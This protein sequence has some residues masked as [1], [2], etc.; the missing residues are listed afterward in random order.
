MEYIIREAGLKD[1]SSLKPLHKEV[2]DI[3]AEA[4]PDK[5]KRTEETLDKTYYDELIS[6]S[7]SKVYIVE[8]QGEIAGFTILKKTWPPKWDIKVQAPVVFMHDLGVKDSYRRRGIARLLF[9]KA[10]EFT[11]ECGAVSLELGVWEFNQSAIDFYEKMGMTTQARK[12]EI[13]ID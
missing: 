1:Y 9:E 6:S 11:K 4:R 8:D 7:D 2:H 10:V 12:M 5:Y 3:H 13:K